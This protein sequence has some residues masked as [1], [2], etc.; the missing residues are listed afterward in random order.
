MRAQPGDFVRGPDVTG[1][2]VAGRVIDRHHV[3]TQYGPFSSGSVV[4]VE[5]TGRPTP[6]VALVR[7]YEITH[8]ERQAP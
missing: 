1:L 4:V 2:R 7:E 8:V 6:L 5:V 3:S